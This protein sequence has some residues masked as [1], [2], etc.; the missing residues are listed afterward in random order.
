MFCEKTLIICTHK[1][2]HHTSIKNKFIVNTHLYQN[3]LFYLQERHNNPSAN[4]AATNLNF[5]VSNDKY[6]I[7]H[8]FVN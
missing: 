8:S 6:L 4:Y 3:I 1:H 5:I 2:I 7:L